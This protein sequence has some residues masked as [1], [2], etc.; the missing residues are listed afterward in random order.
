GTCIVSQTRDVSNTPVT[1]FY[2]FDGH[3]NISF[4]TDAMGAVTASYDYDGWGSVVASTG[5]TP[6]TRLYTGEELDPDLGL[7]NLR[8]RQYRPGSGRFLT[9]DPVYGEI[10]RPSSLNRYVYA[11]GNPV[12][13]LD[14]SGTSAV[15]EYFFSYA[16]GFAV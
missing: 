2:G 7:I 13:F 6:N 12:S 8:A 5:N 16:V 10:K 3:G 14:P 15:L 11:S 9:L 4:L 1:N